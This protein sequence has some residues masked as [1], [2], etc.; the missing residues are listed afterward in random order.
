[1]VFAPVKAV[2]RPD[3]LGTRFVVGFVTAKDPLC[4]GLFEE[5]QLRFRH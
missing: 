4:P 5:N 3:S 1:M 2:L